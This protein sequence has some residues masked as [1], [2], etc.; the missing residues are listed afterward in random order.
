MTAAKPKIL[1]SN[2]DGIFAPGLSALYD[3]M[4][5]IGDVT[6][7][8][9]ASEQSAVGHA[10]TILD[11]L[12][13]SD[14]KRDDKFFGYAVNGTPAD[15]VKMA[16]WALLEEKPDLVISGINQGSNAGINAMYSGTVSAATE[17]AILDIPSF[18]I[19]L[20]SWTYREFGYAATF[21]RELAL[22]V[23]SHG[24][25]SGTLL[26]VNVPAVA[27][28]EIAGVMVTRQSQARYLEHFDKRVDPANRVYYW[29][30]GQKMQPGAELDLDDRAVQENYVSIT[31]LHYD[32]T[33]YTFLETLKTWELPDKTP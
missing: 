12:R 20:A 33:N 14:F 22:K 23:L 18:A 17:G 16:Y 25:P 15:C 1:L 3:E 21:A 2:D 31:P 30:S 24:L 19:S 27:A 28:E 10:I 9:P 32:L 11:P 26:N 5:K 7:V 29:L 6:V 8:A 4:R 13:V